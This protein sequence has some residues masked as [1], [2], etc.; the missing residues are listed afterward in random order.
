MHHLRHLWLLLIAIIQHRIL[1]GE[2]RAHELRDLDICLLDLGLEHVL[3]LRLVGRL[4]AGARGLELLDFL[5]GCR[6][7]YRGILDLGH[8]GLH[9]EG[10]NGSA[11]LYGL[12]HLWLEL[13]LALG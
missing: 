6:T 3:D 8:V 13:D 7:L 5:H 12:G 1:A 4:L 9:C 11:D 2:R 10:D